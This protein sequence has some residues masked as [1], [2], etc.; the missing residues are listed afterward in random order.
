MLKT[1]IVGL[2]VISGNAHHV[3]EQS[4]ESLCSIQQNACIEKNDPF[5]LQSADF[6]R[7]TKHINAVPLLHPYI[8]KN[9]FDA[10]GISTTERIVMTGK[11]IRCMQ[12]FNAC[13]EE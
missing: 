9:W 3:V 6:I 8:A 4:K 13:I 7:G 10:M 12:D 1:I 5:W 11:A 2:L